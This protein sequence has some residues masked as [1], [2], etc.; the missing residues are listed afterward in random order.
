MQWEHKVR[1]VSYWLF[2]QPSGGSPFPVAEPIRGLD[3]SDLIH[4]PA[5][6][7]RVVVADD[8]PRVLESV[9]RVLGPDFQVVAAVDDGLELVEAVRG[10]APDLILLDVEMPQM[11][12]IRAARE[13]RSLG[14]AVRIIFLTVHVEEDYVDAARKCGDGYVLKSRMASEL[15]PAIED[16]LNGKFF[17]SHRFR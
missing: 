9:R 14:S 8:H 17:V 6:P 15:L 3:M 5:P 2:Y 10:L 16:A 13:V 12:G 7:L 11:D 4:R 1:Q